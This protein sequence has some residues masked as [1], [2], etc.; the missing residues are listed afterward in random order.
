LSGSQNRGL[1][2][3]SRTPGAGWTRVRSHSDAAVEPVAVL[4]GAVDGVRHRMPPM[5]I[6][7]VK[8]EWLR[9]LEQ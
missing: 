1:R 9:A 7:Q 8:A 6:N 2:A 5:D 3:K 4:A